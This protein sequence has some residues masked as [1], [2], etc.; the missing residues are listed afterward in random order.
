MITSVF[1]QSG[2]WLD[3]LNIE[4]KKTFPRASASAPRFNGISSGCSIA[5][6]AQRRRQG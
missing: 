6:G 2:G 4:K 3:R 5:G 1:R